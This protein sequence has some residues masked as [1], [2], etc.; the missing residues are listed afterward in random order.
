M[1][2]VSTVIVRLMSIGQNTLK[3]DH[4]THGTAR[5]GRVIGLGAL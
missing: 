5:H 1:I 2:D 3:T 4:P